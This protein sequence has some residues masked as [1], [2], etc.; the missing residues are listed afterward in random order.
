MFNV[1]TMMQGDSY[2]LGIKLQ[3]DTG[4]GILPEAVSDIEITIGHLTKT[5]AGGEIKYGEN[6][7]LFPLTQEESFSLTAGKPYG[8]V[9]IKWASG[10]V[11]GCKLDVPRLDESRS[12]EVL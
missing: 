9:R 12:R 4:A 8:Q 7:W 10:E 2:N 3:D 1:W 6:V 5:Y 11:D